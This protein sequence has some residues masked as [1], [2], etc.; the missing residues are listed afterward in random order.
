MS[1]TFEPK[2]VLIDL[3]KNNAGISAL[4]GNRVFPRRLDRQPV[5]PAL[6]ITK[7]SNYN[8]MA[9]DGA[10]GL[11]ES[12]LQ[13]D[14]FAKADYDVENL[15]NTICQEMH[16]CTGTGIQGLFIEED[17]DFLDDALLDV[18]EYGGSLGVTMFWN[19]TT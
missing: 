6:L 12:K 5:M 19:M 14:I 1:A 13:I 8:M 18:D 15:K 11:I 3:I 2:Y 16:G 4:V 10:T 9:H 17:A 7:L